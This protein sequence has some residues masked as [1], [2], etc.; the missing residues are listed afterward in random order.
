MRLNAKAEFSPRLTPPLGRLLEGIGGGALR[1]ASALLAAPLWGEGQAWA[2]ARALEGL[3]L[4][5]SQALLLARSLCKGGPASLQALRER[6]AEPGPEE[7]A[8]WSEYLQAPL[9]GYRSLAEAPHLLAL[10]AAARR[11]QGAL[12]SLEAPPLEAPEGVEALGDLLEEPFPLV[13]VSG[14]PWREALAEGIALA[15]AVAAAKGLPGIHVGTQTRLGGAEAHA[16][17]SERLGGAERLGQV[18]TLPWQ[19]D[20]WLSGP[21]G[22]FF[23]PVVAGSLDAVLRSALRLPEADL[24][25]LAL[26][27]KVPVLAVPLEWPRGFAALKAFLAWARRFRTG[28]VLLASVFPPSMAKALL[29]AAGYGDHP[30]PPLGVVAYGRNGPRILRPFRPPRTPLLPT[31]GEPEEELLEGSQG[32]WLLLP[33]AE[34]AIRTYEA[35]GREGMLVERAGRPYARILPDGRTLLLY[36]SRLRVGVGLVREPLEADLVVGTSSSLQE[37]IPKGRVLLRNPTPQ[38]LLHAALGGKEVRFRFAP[39][40]PRFLP[41]EVFLEGAVLASTHLE[42]DEEFLRGAATLYEGEVFRSWQEVRQGALEPLLVQPGSWPGTTL[43]GARLREVEDIFLV[44]EDLQAE[45]GLQ[46][47]SYLAAEVADP[48]RVVEWAWVVERV[49]GSLESGL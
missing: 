34:E 16:L 49:P 7:V 15:Q 41:K 10:V 3:D 13:L 14:L 43:P 35:L 25:L 47:P 42:A 27:H 26:A 8:F 29:E 2:V 36:H 30:P 46:A 31:L 44:G 20:S 18:P 45:E 48:V 33:A 1:A 22:A 17:L 38:P 9:E 19:A 37:R 32:G 11:A 4:A 21:G 24:R 23:A 12:A 40:Y 5:K 39:P 6:E 28:A